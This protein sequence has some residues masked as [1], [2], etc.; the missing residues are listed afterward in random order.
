MRWI[1][2]SYIDIY[3]KYFN[4]H[5]LCGYCTVP[6]AILQDYLAIPNQSK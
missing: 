4:R 3:S 5:E 1:Y 2:F 6:L